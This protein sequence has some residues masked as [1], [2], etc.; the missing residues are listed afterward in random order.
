[1]KNQDNE[2]SGMAME[3]CRKGPA[4]LAALRRRLIL[5]MAHCVRFALRSR[6]PRSPLDRRILATAAS[7]GLAPGHDHGISEERIIERLSSWLCDRIVGRLKEPS[8]PA[9]HAMETVCT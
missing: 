9:R 4:A 2:W 6:E 1:M 5:E 3:A 7:L 8:G